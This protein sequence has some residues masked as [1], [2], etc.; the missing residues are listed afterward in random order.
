MS[1]EAGLPKPEYEYTFFVN[2]FG[3]KYLNSL[4]RAAK[5]GP[6]NRSIIF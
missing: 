3:D 1:I 6:G 4:L 2:N 5:P